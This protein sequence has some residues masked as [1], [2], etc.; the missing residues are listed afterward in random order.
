MNNVKALTESQRTL[1]E[2]NLGLISYAMTKIPIYLFDSREDAFQIGAIG[3]M[4]AAR[5]YDLSRNILFSTY[6]MPCIFNELRMA[7]RHINSSNPPGRT[8]SYDAPLPNADGDTLSLIDMLPSSDQ[9]A[10]ERIST[11]ETLG[12]LSPPCGT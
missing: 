11:H 5:H 9:P 7:L 2:A 1:V 12:R 8:V 3:L 4:K 6:A 10:D